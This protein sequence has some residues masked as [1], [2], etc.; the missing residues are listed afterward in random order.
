MEPKVRSSRAGITSLPVA[1]W[2]EELG[3]FVDWDE[4]QQ[5]WFRNQ[6]T[7]KLFQDL[8]HPFYWMVKAWE[9]HE[10]A[11]S[12]WANVKLLTQARPRSNR[13]DGNG[14]PDVVFMLAG[15]SLENLL[16]AKRVCAM[17]WP[18]DD[19][20]YGSIAKGGHRLDEL[21]Q[22]SAV[23]TNKYDRAI[24][25]TLSHY[26]R[27]SGRYFLPRTIGE[28]RDHP[29]H[30]LSS[31]DLWAGYVAVRRKV[32]K[33]LSSAMRKWPREHMTL[34]NSAVESGRAKEQAAAQRGR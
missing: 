10:A 1:S 22:K 6:Q 12:L 2:S 27:W 26:V 31:R 7:V 20:T 24:L 14:F 15:M 16:K 25:R 34:S 5:P 17:A 9:L 23:R 19:H 29:E 11:T 3:R 18:V 32:S 8:R 21:S 33:Q 4:M 28:F 30:G 13:P